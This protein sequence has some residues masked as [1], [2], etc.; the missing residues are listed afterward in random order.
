MI[1][2]CLL[3]LN[4]F[5]PQPLFLVPVNSEDRSYVGSIQLTEIGDFGIMRKA[6]P[7]VKE[8]LHTG[9]DILPPNSNY[10]SDEP[11]FP[12]T[13]GIVIS[14]REDGPFANIIIE[15]DING[16]LVWSVYEHIAGIKVEI[17]EHV[18]PTRP[19][20]RFFK[21]E[22]LNK[23]G[24]QFNHFHFEILKSQPI[25]IEASEIHPNRNFNAYTLSCHTPSDLQQHYYSPL[26]FL[27]KMM[28]KG[29]Y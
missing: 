8:H 5:L 16:E 23:I 25:P 26:I 3:V 29:G 9:I 20:A 7:T 4:L 13:D 1:Y 24:W 21:A 18:I 19:I 22:E 17:G 2:S 11:I 15:H 10:E 6:R 27:R 12:F 14:K 28:T